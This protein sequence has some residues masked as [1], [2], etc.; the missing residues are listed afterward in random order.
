MNKN[1]LF[2]E[3]VNSG[4]NVFEY[5]FKDKGSETTTTRTG[6]Q[7]FDAWHLEGIAEHIKNGYTDV[8]D[9]RTIEQLREQ[10]KNEEALK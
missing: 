7:P 1:D 8:L 2:I 3:A 5:C 9:F 6:F 10:T 4:Q